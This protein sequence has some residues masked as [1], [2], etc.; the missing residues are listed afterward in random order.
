MWVTTP[1]P[2]PVSATVWVPL[3]KKHKLEVNFDCNAV[4]P[5]CGTEPY[6][7]L[8]WGDDHCD[9]YDVGACVVRAA[10]KITKRSTQQPSNKSHIS[11]AKG[12]AA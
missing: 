9:D 7:V 11:K 8:F 12:T 10:E 4:S 1:P 5:P 2:K 3:A 6:F